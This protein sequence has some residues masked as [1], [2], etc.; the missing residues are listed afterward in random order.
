MPTTYLAR[1]AT[2]RNFYYRETVPRDVRD[3]L[4]RRDGKAPPDVWR[5]LGTSDP[6]LAKSRLVGERAAQHKIWDDLRASVAPGGEIPTSEEMAD[7]VVEHVHDVFIRVTQD[8]LREQIRQGMDVTTEVE[9]R[10]AHLGRANFIP[11]DQDRAAMERIA[12]KLSSDKRWSIA[13]D[14][15]ATQ[16]AFGELVEMVTKAVHS[17]RLTIVEELA[18]R[19]PQM[20]REE[21][22]GRLGVKRTSFAKAGETIM[23]LF[24]RYETE[25]L[26]ERR[27]RA[28]TIATERKVIAHFA[29]FVGE[30]RSVADIGPEDIREF[31]RALSAVPERWTA[32]PELKG[33]AIREAAR[34]WED[35]AGRGRSPTT[36]R[37]ELSAVSTFF[38]WLKTNAFYAA[39]NPTADF[40]P[41]VNKARHKYPPYTKDEL[42]AVF[43]SPL[44]HRCRTIKPHQ[45]GDDEV[46][47]WR[48]WIPLCA[49]FSGARAGEI[50][51]LSCAD[52]RQEDGTWVFDFNDEPGVGE[53][54][55]LKTA[56]SR[57]LVPVHSALM[58]LGFVDHVEDSRRR[59]SNQVFP[60][61]SPGPRDN[62]SY[63]PSKFW[64]RYLARISVKRPG[65]ALHSF[66]HGFADESRRQG[67]PHE[68]LQAL[69]GHSDGSQTGHYGTL[70][71]GTLKQRHEA[72][73]SLSFFGLAK[74]LP[75]PSSS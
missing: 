69:L 7:A 3:I 63:H 49:L 42:V 23:E 61:L 36:I 11:D 45:A 56:S 54:K 21:V 48:Y 13:P 24:G 62:W 31:K 28:D 65:L 51:Q 34:K 64:Q 75:E 53:E 46:R 1:R 41:Q 44:F 30:Q 12:S 58:Q 4:V 25:A 70:R 72:I 66:R 18:G 57:R 68:V 74:G 8:K 5:S 9:R 32:H 27:K 26:R 71:P 14:L 19:Q 37:R 35:R 40:F 10:R 22:L 16:S 20:S 39:A 73:E 47:D 43:S 60:E 52:V 67:V 38:Q 2:S 15:P 50:T 29:S 17:G 33:L 59:G 55:R 6:R